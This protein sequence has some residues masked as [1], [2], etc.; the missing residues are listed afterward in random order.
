[1]PPNQG[2]LTDGWVR[3][4]HPSAAE[5]QAFGGRYR[6]EVGT[7]LLEATL[8][9]VA[10]QRNCLFAAAAVA[11]QTGARI[12]QLGRGSDACLVED[13]GNRKRVQARR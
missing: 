4:A 2:L 11:Q 12:S 6:A 3:C 10:P 7:G 13:T 5:A 8:G 9:A 1:M